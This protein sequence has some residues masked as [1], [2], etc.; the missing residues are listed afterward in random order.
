MR[1]WVLVVAL[2]AGLAGCQTAAETKLE[3]LTPTALTQ[4]QVAALHDGVRRTLKDPGSAQ[5]GE[6]RAG[7]NEKG[8]I[9]ACGWVNAKNSYGGY[10]GKQP[11]LALYLSD[12]GKF[13]AQSIGATEIRNTVIL[14]TCADSG[15]PLPVL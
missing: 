2:G 10:T 8:G 15:L 4:Q 1:E 11:Y 3:V 12:T 6:H 7:L 5:F 9:V 14:K 13:Y